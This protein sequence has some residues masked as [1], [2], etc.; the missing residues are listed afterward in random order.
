MCKHCLSVITISNTKVNNKTVII[1][2][3][4]K[5]LISTPLP[6]SLNLKCSDNKVINVYVWR[7]Y[8]GD[9]KERDKLQFYMES[10]YNVHPDKN[11][12]LENMTSCYEEIK[13]LFSDQELR[14]K[15]PPLISYYIIF[16]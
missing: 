7:Q 8:Q 13:G 11:I 4:S 16:M 6:N 1:W 9:T 2:K 15:L 3:T 12:T 14:S 5:L 10:F